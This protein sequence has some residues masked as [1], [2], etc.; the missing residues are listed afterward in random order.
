MAVRD[1]KPIGLDQW[2]SPIHWRDHLPTEI[3]VQ[4]RLNEQ[5]A[6][7]HNIHRYLGHRIDMK[8]CRYRV[9]NELCAFGDLCEALEIYSKGW[10][11]RRNIFRWLETHPEVRTI[12]SR[13]KKFKWNKE[14]KMERMRKVQSDAL[15]EYR[16]AKKAR[17]AKEPQEPPEGETEERKQSRLARTS[18]EFDDM[19]ELYDS[20]DSEAGWAGR[21]ISRDLPHTI[22][23]SFL[24]HVLRALVNALTML[25]AGNNVTVPGKPWREIVHGDIYTLNVFLKPNGNNDQGDFTHDDG[26]YE[27]D[28][29]V[30]QERSF[31]PHQYPTLVLADFDRAFFTL[32]STP[33]SYADNPY[34]YLLGNTPT[35]FHDIG[36][37]YAPEQYSI[38][39]GYRGKDREQLTSQADIWA[40]GQ[41]MW[42]LVM[43]LP[44]KQGYAQ[45]P[46]VD[47]SGTQGRLLSNGDPYP[48]ELVDSDVF[49]GE[50]PF[51]ASNAYSDELKEIV[52]MCLRY[53]A[54]DRP[55]VQE[56]R[57]LVEN[58]QEHYLKYMDEDDGD[59][60]VRLMV[61]R[62]VME[63]GLGGRFDARK[64]RKLRHGSDGE[65]EEDDDDE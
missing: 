56:L 36:S 28:D 22:P 15:R 43:N 1:V 14:K 2:T 62:E 39:E 51:E 53:R 18:K 30:N 24:W 64:E 10:R 13:A 26:Q 38:Y 61:E 41:V 65:E 34:H 8:Q 48:P 50:A 5:G 47:N 32:Q 19:S 44:G 6:H 29:P 25:H 54:K 17:K 49:S 21:Q 57:D 20:N 11:R 52:R 4:V 40:I 42:N 35:Q 37:R 7:E 63:L 58:G 23:E 33:N 31:L 16:A 12:H 45:E 55:G 27:D 3:A 60:R 59:G 46:F 9:Y